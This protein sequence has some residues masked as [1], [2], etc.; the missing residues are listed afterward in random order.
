M[1]G[2]RLVYR[3][4]PVLKNILNRPIISADG[5]RGMVIAY[6][7]GGGEAVFVVKFEHVAT[8]RYLTSEGLLGYRVYDTKQERDAAWRAK[9]A[10][11]VQRCPAELVGV[12]A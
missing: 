3:S 10:T 4:E 12:A 2:K 9:H 7:S 11:N 6:K 5:E 8:L 1:D